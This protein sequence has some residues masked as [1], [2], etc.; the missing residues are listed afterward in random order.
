MFVLFVVSKDKRQNAGQQEEE[1][2][3]DEVQSIR[4]F[5]KIPPGHECLS[6]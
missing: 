3:K 5:Q 6:F 4:G 2:C 1:P